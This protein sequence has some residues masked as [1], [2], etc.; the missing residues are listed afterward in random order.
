MTMSALRKLIRISLAASV[1]A[2]LSGCATSNLRDTE[3]TADRSMAEAGDGIATMRANSSTTVR[4]HEHGYWVANQSQPLAVK[5]ETVFCNLTAHDAEPLTL[6]MFADRVQRICGVPVHVSADALRYPQ[7]SADTK[8]SAG[9]KDDKQTIVLGPSGPGGGNMAPPPEPTVKLNWEG[10][11]SGLLDSVAA[12]LGVHWKIKDGAVR[13]F[14]T[15][16][17]TFQIY[18]LPGT[19][20]LSSSVTTNTMSTMGISGGSSGG[21][22]GGSGDGGISGQAGSAQSVAT[23]LT[24]S[25]MNDVA[26]AV[27]AMVTPGQ[28]KFTLAPGTGSMTVTD[29]PDVLDRIASYVENQN[30]VLTMQVVLNVKILSVTFDRTDQYGVDWNLAYNSARLG[31]Q[32]ISPA[33]VDGANAN[34]HV[35]KGPFKDSSLLVKALSAQ[36]KV[37]IVTQP[38]V[39][40]LNLQAVPMQVAT[41]TGYVASVTSNQVAQVGTSVGIEPGTVTTGFN[42]ML[43]PYAMADRQV[44]LQ[45]NISLSNLAKL[46]TFGDKNTGQVQLPTVDL[47]AFAQKVRLRSGETLALSGFEQNSDTSKR[48]GVGSPNN[49]ALGGSRYGEKHHSVIVIL[50]TPVVAG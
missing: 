24:S 17:R 11:L 10:S 12:Q 31:S 1:L 37:S 49:Q 13:I 43:L 41:Q 5:P 26:K 50:I 16:T 32:M 6:S 15:E 7:A 47:R 29:T 14:R 45:Y 35:L 19:D 33:D 27:Q 3:R 34:V 36:G 8:D 18:A 30:K 39:T 4:V 20:A 48:S 9:S 22:G 21:G 38:S 2:A 25:V 28:G 23:T 46:E 40:T 44:L 42:M